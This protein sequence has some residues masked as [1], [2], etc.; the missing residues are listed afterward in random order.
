MM[1]AESDASIVALKRG[2]AEPWISMRY[3]AIALA[4]IAVVLLL[5]VAAI[6]T[7]YMVCATVAYFFMIAGLILREEKRTHFILMIMATMLDLGVVLSLEVQRNAIKTA[8]D[9]TLTPWQQSHIFTSLAALLLYFPVVGLGIYKAVSPQQ[10]QGIKG[11]H[12]RLGVAAF[13]LR[14]LGFALMFTLLSHVKK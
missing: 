1:N 12:A 2:G 10:Y 14:S 3:L 4:F 13:V 9:M 8:V 7:S 11:T 5:T 6:G